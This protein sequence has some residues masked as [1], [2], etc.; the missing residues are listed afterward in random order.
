MDRERI[1]QLFFF[2]LLAV[3]AYELY[4]LLSPFLT[5]IIWA[6]LLGFV[7]HPLMDEARRLIKSRSAAAMAITLGVALGV[8][9]PGL[10]LANLLASEAQSLYVAVS[11]LVRTGGI[12]PLRERAMHSRL[13]TALD[14]ALARFRINLAASDSTVARFGS[15]RLMSCRLS[16]RTA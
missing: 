4:L 15:S 14:A 1:V 7:F 6:M 10:W 13:V 9:L 3:M 2:G 11:E 5:P 12:G 16:S 8:I